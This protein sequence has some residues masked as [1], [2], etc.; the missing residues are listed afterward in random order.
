MPRSWARPPFGGTQPDWRNNKQRL[1]LNSRI[2][3]LWGTRAS[4]CPDRV[5]CPARHA[6]GR[7]TPLPFSLSP[8]G[9][10]PSIRGCRGPARPWRNCASRPV[11]ERTRGE[12]PRPPIPA[13][14]LAVATRRSTTHWTEVSLARRRR[15]AGVLCEP[16]Q[17]RERVGTPQIDCLRRR[18]GRAEAGGHAGRVGGHRYEAGAHVR[19]QGA[20][21]VRRPRL[22]PR[23]G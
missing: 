17:R 2:P 20:A 7:R 4:T 21:R 19:T 14:R 23:G 15:L 22:A 6:S 3:T 13:T 12:G 9:S 16:C 5:G 11:S 1:G 10:R 18:R 8:L